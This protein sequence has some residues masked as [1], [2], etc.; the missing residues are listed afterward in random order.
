MPEQIS[1]GHR[2]FPAV[3][4]SLIIITCLFFFF[5]A[6]WIFFCGFTAPLRSQAALSASVSRRAAFLSGVP[7]ASARYCSN[8]SLQS[9]LCRISRKTY[10]TVFLSM[11]PIETYDEADYLYFRAMT[12]LKTS[13]LLPDFSSLQK[14]MEYITRSGN[15]ISTVYLGVRPDK[16]TAG[17]ISSLAAAYPELAF[18]VIIAYPSIEYWRHLSDFRYEQTLAA[19]CDFLSAV[20]DASDMHVYFFSAEEWLISNPGLYTGEWRLTPDAARFVMTNSDIFHSYQVT[21][22]NAAKL[23][24]GL[25]R[26]TAAQRTAPTAYPDLRDTAIVFFGDSVIGNYT[27][28]MSIP[29]VVRG[30]TGASVYN[31]GYNGNSAAMHEKA[32]ITLPGIAD[33][34]ARQDISV[35]P[36]DTQLYS[37]FLEYEINPPKTD[38]KLCFIISYG[39]NDYFQQNP[40]SSEDPYDITTYSGAIRTA[41][42]CLREHYGDARIFHCTPTYTALSDEGNS[43]S[44]EDYVSAVID[45]S[46]EMNVEIIDNYGSLGINEKNHGVYLADKVHPTE[47]GR[48]MVAQEIISA[49]CR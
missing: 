47:R 42:C 8:A 4:N 21:P 11:Y 36:R 45:I 17:E 31:L 18:E 38:C 30:L 46:R 35:L 19:Y 40:I 34:F 44:L 10:D 25:R 22:D 6:L 43:L 14:Y 2:K 16:I 29:G 26:L 41:V 33:A 1:H 49:I 37:G 48:F 3:R 32:V 12:V 27:D 24:S 9:D 5:A 20:S 23:S 13:F 39:L 7:M 28:G 15:Q